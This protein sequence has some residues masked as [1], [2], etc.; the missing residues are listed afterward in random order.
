MSFR[1]LLSLVVGFA[2]GIGIESVWNL[3]PYFA[4]WF[5]LLA[6]VVALVWR[7]TSEACPTPCLV[8]ISVFFLALALG[9]FR[10]ELH[11]NTFSDSLFSSVGK[12]VLISGEVTRE[13]DQR[14]QLQMLTVE[15]GD[16]KIQVSTDK[17]LAV[18]YGDVVT[19][20]G[21]LERPESFE[22]DLGRVFDYASYLKA[23]G[24]EYTIS[25]AEVEVVGKGEGNLFIAWLLTLK[26]SFMDQLDQV[27]IEPGGALADG[28]LLGLN[29]G[30]GDKLEEDFR[31]SGIIH[32]VVLS[33]YNIML[34][35]TFVMFLL[36]FFLRQKSRMIFGLMAIVS[37]ALIVGLSAT[38]VRASIMAALLL[39]AQTFGR[40]YD[41]LRSLLVAGLIMLIINPYLL[42]FDIGFQLSFMATLGLILALPWLETGKQ[43]EVL[44][45]VRGYVVATIATQ[46]AVLPLL[47]YHIGQVSVVSVLV[48]VLVLPM[49]PVAMLGAFLSATVHYILPVIGIA[50]GSITQLSLSYII[51]IAE[52]FSGLPFATIEFTAISPWWVLIL[53]GLIGGG[54]WWFMKR[55]ENGDL[56]LS[57]WKI[58]E[59][60]SLKNDAD[61]PSA[62]A[63]D[64][65]PKMFR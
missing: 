11:E 4:I 30:L 59:E 37:F 5:L 43:P 56:S 32:I 63:P 40:S 3:N 45:S 58:I 41:V 15:H 38:V 39:I 52:W 62:S 25:F 28:L 36:S 49:V 16:T 18:M 44:T 1:V 55:G 60:E 57:D 6:L 29:Q 7:R 61:V 42:L 24:I 22:T 27:L 13:P 54:C 64:S 53:Y 33:G 21:V 51:K 14:S 46:I 20:T 8:L 35:V 50:F 23:K 47:I 10:T 9:Q 48:N 19:V 31:R 17:N 26:Y 12:E 65:L 34:V 2:V